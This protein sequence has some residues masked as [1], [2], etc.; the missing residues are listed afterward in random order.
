MALRTG[1]KRVSISVTA[2][3]FDR[4]Q[5]ELSAQDYPH[6]YLSYYLDKCLDDLDNHLTGA[7][8]ELTAM[9]QVLIDEHLMRKE[10]R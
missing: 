1:K 5:A 4:V 7:P 6:G 8:V 3:L 9:E 2:G 10:K